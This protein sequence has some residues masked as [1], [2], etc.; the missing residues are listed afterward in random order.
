MLSLFTF[1]ALSCLRYEFWCWSIFQAWW[2]LARLWERW[3]FANFNLSLFYESVSF[4]C[5][6]I[7]P[8]WFYVERM[9]HFWPIVSYRASGKNSVRQVPWHA[10]YFVQWRSHGITADLF[11]F[12]C[13]HDENFSF[14]LDTTGS[15]SSFVILFHYILLNLRSLCDLLKL[16]EHNSKTHFV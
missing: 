14:G 1:S 11:W 5:L 10:H 12:T 13:L 6:S 2:L 9:C 8:S 15:L 4:S 3:A 7:L 16:F